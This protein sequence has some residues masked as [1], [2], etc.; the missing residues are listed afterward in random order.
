MPEFLVA[1][2]PIGNPLV[3][4]AFV[5]R[6]SC[7]NGAEVHDANLGNFCDADGPP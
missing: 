1:Y 5:D 6:V 2:A 7:I 4:L 3:T